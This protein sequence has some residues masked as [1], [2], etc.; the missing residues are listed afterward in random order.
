MK[1]TLNYL[2]VIAF[3]VSGFQNLDAQ[4]SQS[5]K[6]KQ[7]A[8]FQKTVKLVEG[9]QFI[10]EA[11]R[12]FPQGGRSIDLTT[13]YGFIKTTGS[14]AESH[15]P[16]FGRA[17]SVEYGGGGG[18]IEFKGE[19]QNLKIETHQRKMKL[20]FTFEVKDK[21]TFKVSMDIG[22]NGNATVNIS[23]N[24]RSNIS[25]YGKISAIDDKQMNL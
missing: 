15:L 7:Q 24:N 6:D 17:Y 21:D 2:I 13:N 12:A 1:S 3:L 19:M 18:G 10:F 5:K 11:Q 4:N 25:Y 16:F 23:S 20:L 8:D 9:G 14:D 22:S